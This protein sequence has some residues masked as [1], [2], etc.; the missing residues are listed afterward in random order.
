MFKQLTCAAIL[1]M[2]MLHATDAAELPLSAPHYALEQCCKLCPE[3]QDPDNYATSLSKEFKVLIEGKENWLFR[4]HLDFLVP[5]EPRVD[6]AYKELK[7]FSDTLK[8]KGTTLVVVFVPTRGMLHSEYLPEPSRSQYP[9]EL[10]RNNYR[11][12][13]NKM[14]NEGI[15]T[16]DLSKLF[17]QPHKDFFFKRDHHWTPYGARLTAELAAEEIKKLADYKN[18]QKIEYKT[19]PSGIVRRA[20][21]H[22]LALKDVCGFDLSNQ[23]V[24][25]FV[26][27][28][29]NSDTNL[30]EESI[31]EISLA[32]TSNSTSLYNFTGFL[33]QSL[34][35]DIN[36]K[37][38]AGGAMAGALLQYLPSDDF[39]NSPPKILIWELPGQYSF[40]NDLLYR[41]LIPL[42][43]NGCKNKTALLANESTLNGEIHEVL[44]NIDPE[45]LHIS[46]N[47][48]VIDLQFSDPAIKE[49]DATV[50]YLT[51]RKD[52]IKTAVPP[53]VNNN[54]RFVFELSQSDKLKAMNLLSVDVRK[55]A[56]YPDNLKIKASLCELE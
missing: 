9:V 19:Y 24:E 49:I 14:K 54:G 47:N 29:L 51:H 12:I 52:R 26:T 30:F 48:Y 38:L 35:V 23:V 10:A 44:F 15:I 39:Q 17:D 27:E 40:D 1:S 37:S 25:Q 56:S 36:N 20:G 28:P 34:G 45:K 55:L 50:W 7:R 18:I 22:Q 2:A 11:A 21:T 43:D 42:S 13:I 32:G 41:Q 5:A 8:S 31:P 53:R 16:V 33:Q 3:A 46:G 6:G 4:S